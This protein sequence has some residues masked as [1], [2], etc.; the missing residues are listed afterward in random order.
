MDRS[1]EEVLIPSSVNLDGNQD[2]SG[3][4]TQVL[5]GFSP[6]TPLPIGPNLPRSGF[7]NRS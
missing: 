3:K 5:E 1:V 7:R 2:S 6:L 4:L